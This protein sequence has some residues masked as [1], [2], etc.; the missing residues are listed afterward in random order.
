M[1]KQLGIEATARSAG[2]RAE[3]YRLLTDS[4]TWSRWTPFSAVT[5]VE[6]APG[7]GEGVGAVKQT[8]LRGMTSRERIVALTPD[9]QVSYAYIGGIFTLFLNHYV[10]VVD[11]DDDGG[12]TSIHWHATFSERFPGSGW[13]PRRSIGAFLRRCADGLAAT[14][15]GHHP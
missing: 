7:G 2:S 10:A 11:L 3:V 4:S 1:T 5:L 9:R 12:G 8:R 14:A 13:L 15:S 6:E